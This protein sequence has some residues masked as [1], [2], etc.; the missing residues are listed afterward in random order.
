MIISPI[1]KGMVLAPTILSN[2]G[3]LTNYGLK[4]GFILCAIL[5]TFFFIPFQ[6]GSNQNS[7]QDKTFL[8][9][10]TTYGSALQNQNNR[11]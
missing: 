5:Y 3:A 11:K 4:I 9:T 8:Y 7:S 2:F 1:I 6:S 10:A